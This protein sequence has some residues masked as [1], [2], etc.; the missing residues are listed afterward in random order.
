[1]TVN[2][3]ARVVVARAYSSHSG[4]QPDHTSIPFLSFE[5][6]PNK[7]MT[8][9]ASTA[10]SAVLAA[11]IGSAVVYQALVRAPPSYSRMVIKTA[12]T[13]LLSIFSYLR[14]GPTFLVGALALGS[15]GD[16]FLA[17]NDETSFL[18]GLASF[19]FAHI[20]YIILFFHTG[21]GRGDISA[22]VEILYN[23]DSWRFGTAGALAVLAPVMIMQLMPRVGND[24]RA[25][26]AVYSL[27]IFVMAL[28]ALTL[29]R[30]EIIIGAVMFTGSDSILAAARFLVPATSAHQAWMHHAVWVLYYGGQLLIA[31]GVIASE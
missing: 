28:T 29:K 7:T 19:L 16:A 24:L 31:L 25:P 20:L 17:W 8:T 10:D 21:P 6:L 3:G 13:A 14:G 5:K 1:M 18:L 12:S 15:T 26:V 30:S 23:G 27:T 9:N 2:L 22:K 4:Q 11:S